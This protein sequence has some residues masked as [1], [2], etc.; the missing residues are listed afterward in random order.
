MDELEFDPSVSA[1]NIGVSVKNGVVT[2]NGTVPSY[3]EK[4]AAERDAFRVAGVKAV[5]E[6]IEV[7]LLGSNVRTDA[8]I[9]T[10]AANA[11][12][13]RATI[14]SSVQVSVEEGRVILRGEVEWAYQR[15]SAAE[16]VRHL[17][18][19]RSIVNHIAVRPRMRPDDIKKRIVKALMRSVEK[20][21]TQIH[22]EAVDGTV[23]L[24]GKVHSRTEL[25]DANWAAWSTPGV[26]RVENKLAIQ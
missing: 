16:A 2:L 22:V 5:A 25:N 14:P 7:R 4:Y 23:T 24:T 17:S 21:A 3:G 12:E 8:D 26:T 1:E 19:V 10:A 6:E 11:L 20:D 18:G 15:D 9:A 13:W